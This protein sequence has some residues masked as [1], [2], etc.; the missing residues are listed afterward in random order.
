MIASMWL[1]LEQEEPFGMEP[2]RNQNLHSAP[3]YNMDNICPHFRALSPIFWQLGCLLV[4]VKTGIL[5]S[6]A[7]VRP[8]LQMAP[9]RLID[10]ECFAVFSPDTSPARQANAFHAMG[11]DRLFPAGAGTFLADGEQ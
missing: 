2:H 5:D 1:T 9:S 8:P 4:M 3:S 7:I 11:P 6:D 10:E